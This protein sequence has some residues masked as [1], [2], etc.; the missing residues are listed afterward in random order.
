MM[1]CCLMLKR[2]EALWL[3][4]KQMCKMH[5][6]VAQESPDNVP[7]CSNRDQSHREVCRRPKLT[8]SMRGTIISLPGL[9]DLVWLG[10]V[11]TCMLRGKSW[12][13]PTAW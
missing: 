4:M 10:I 6:C 8:W 2:V 11:P 5:T 3:A 9:A 1:G 13:S 7:A 12:G